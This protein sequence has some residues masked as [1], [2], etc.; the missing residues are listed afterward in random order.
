MSSDISGGAYQ[1]ENRY[2]TRKGLFGDAAECVVESFCGKG[3][4]EDARRGL[5]RIRKEVFKAA[6]VEGKRL[7]EGPF[8][9]AVQE[10]LDGVLRDIEVAEAVTSQPVPPPGTLHFPVQ[11]Q[12]TCRGINE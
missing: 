9:L 10:Q 11:T 8:Y 4:G 3:N 12:R 7:C 1:K 2:A 6:A 5:S